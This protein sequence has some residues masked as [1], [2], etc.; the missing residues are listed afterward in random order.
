LYDLERL[1]DQDPEEGFQRWETVKEA[2]LEELR[3]GQ[4]AA[5]AIE[6]PG[7]DLWQ[8]AQF[9]A[10]RKDLADQLAPTGGLE[11]ALVDTL[12][13]TFTEYLRWINAARDWGE[14]EGSKEREHKG[15]PYTLPPLTPRMTY[16][17]AADRAH[18][19]ADRYNR[20]FLRNLRAFR[21]HRRLMGPVNIQAGQVNIA[22]G[23]QQVNVHGGEQN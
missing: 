13:Q 22:A 15:D 19:Q 5:R 1:M 9:L 23:P 11:W 21:D 7:C 3:T 18:D 6:A 20:L 17:Q 14:W 4:R 12:A 10:V 2:A 16:A 8:R